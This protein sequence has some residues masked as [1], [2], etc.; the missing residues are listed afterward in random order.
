[1]DKSFFWLFFYLFVNDY[2]KI[3][4]Y[5]KIINWFRYYYLIDVLFLEENRL[6]IFFVLFFCS[7]YYLVCFNVYFNSFGD[8]KFLYNGCLIEIC[9]I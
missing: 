4:C 2:V 6:K 7:N 5:Y 3:L 8:V 1:M 9:K